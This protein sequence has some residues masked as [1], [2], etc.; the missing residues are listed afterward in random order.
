[1]GQGDERQATSGRGQAASD[2]QLERIKAHPGRAT[3]DDVSWLVEQVEQLRRDL[4]EL[5]T[6]NRRFRMEATSRAGRMPSGGL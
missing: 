4:T 2:W 6:V 1:M 3:M 5:E